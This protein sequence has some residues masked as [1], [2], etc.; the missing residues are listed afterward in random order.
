MWNFLL[1]LLFLFLKFHSLILIFLY[2]V[3]DSAVI[4]IAYFDVISSIKNTYL[5]GG[6]SFGVI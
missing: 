5:P 6:N 4:A 2:V 1:A 3:Y